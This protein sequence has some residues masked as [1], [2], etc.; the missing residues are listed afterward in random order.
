MTNDAFYTW[1]AILSK[2]SVAWLH[3]GVVMKL[4]RNKGEDLIRDEIVKRFLDEMRRDLAEIEILLS[5]Q[6][7]NIDG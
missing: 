3:E 2:T 1:V 5:Q 4:N 7:R 6:K